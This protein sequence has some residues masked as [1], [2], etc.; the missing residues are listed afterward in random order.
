[1]DSCTF[2]KK[3]ERDL[4]NIAKYT[5]KNFGKKQSESY[6]ADILFCLNRLVKNPEIGRSANHFRPNLKRYNFKMH[7]IFYETQ[8][9]GIFIVRVLGQKMDFRRHL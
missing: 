5:I 9:N 4:I 8:K 3:A 6:K 2:S 7:S 1:M